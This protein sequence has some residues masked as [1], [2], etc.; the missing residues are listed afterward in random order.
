[1]SMIPQK[2]FLDQSRT[3]QHHAP[4]KDKTA[5][6]RNQLSL[7]REIARTSSAEVV[8]EAA[9]SKVNSAEVLHAIPTSN[10]S[11]ERTHRNN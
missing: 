11:H 7:V 6:K 10:N 8:A 9:N 1:M 3:T 5:L 2:P 4:H